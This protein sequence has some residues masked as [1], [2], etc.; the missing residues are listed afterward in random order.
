MADFQT[1]Q[2]QFAAYL[3]QPEQV[4]LPP[5]CD[6]RR[7][8]YYHQIFFNNFDGVLDAAFDRLR[9]SI[10]RQNED[11]TVWNDMV[12]RFFQTV[13]QHSPYLADVPARFFDFLGEQTQ[14]PLSEGQI[15]LAAYELACFE[16]KSDQGQPP[17][18]G[19]DIPKDWVNARPVLNPSSLLF[20]SVF[21]VHDL[22]WD[23]RSTEQMPTFLVLVR[24][25]AG[26]VQTHVLS[27][28]SAQLLMLL[29]DH[30]TLTVKEIAH[31][32]AETLQQTPESLLPLLVDQL[33]QWQADE[34]LLGAYSPCAD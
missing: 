17:V 23:P 22:G 18:D 3:R 21:P 13:P 28:A 11:D 10:E 24:D 4:P 5:G 20:E 1:L 12:L 14:W 2:R 25:S 31:L 27:A 8:R 7:M 6:A 30:P 19:V 32:M 34:V 33:K 9:A 15:E 29:N 26:L 16:L